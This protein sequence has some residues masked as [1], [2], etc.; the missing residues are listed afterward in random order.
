MPGGPPLSVDSLGNEAIEGLELTGGPPLCQLFGGDAIKGLKI[1]VPE[2]DR[3][4]FPVDCV[5]W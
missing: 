2:A 1:L 5:Q 4:P 3:G